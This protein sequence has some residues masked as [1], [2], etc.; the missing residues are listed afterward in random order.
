MIYDI[1]REQYGDMIMNNER[2][3]KE[4]III[5]ADVNRVCVQV[6]WVFLIEKNNR[7]NCVINLVGFCNVFVF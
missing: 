1:F 6:G 7:I 4:M 5:K 2:I 3:V